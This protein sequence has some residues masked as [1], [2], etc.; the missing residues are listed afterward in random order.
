LLL[1]PLLACGCVGY[2]TVS[3]RDVGPQE[4]EKF[5]VEQGLSTESL[6]PEQLQ[7][8]WGAPA[9]RRAEDG[10]D[11]WVYER[12]RQWAGLL[13]IAVAVPVPLMLPVAHDQ[14]E[15]GFQGDTL[16]SVRARKVQMHGAICAIVLG[17]CAA[18][19]CEIDP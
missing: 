11:V 9:S 7:S 17:P 2:A 15:L 19:G 14:L 13:L 1:V 3:P 18:P 4:A 5:A 10:R 6:T 12:D 16:V 8:Q